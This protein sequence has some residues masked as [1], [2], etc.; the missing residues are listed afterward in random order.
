[1]PFSQ[2]WSYA[3][4]VKQ[5]NLHIQYY[6]YILFSKI[7]TKDGLEYKFRILPLNSDWRNWKSL[8]VLK[9]KK[10]KRGNS[11]VSFQAINF[12]SICK[13][14]SS[15]QPQGTLGFNQDSRLQ[16]VSTWFADE[17]KCS[18]YVAIL[19]SYTHT[20]TLTH[21]HAQYIIVL[22]I[23]TAQLL[24]HFFELSHDLYFLWSFSN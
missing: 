7:P 14:T 13:K 18:N 2:C 9:K 19:I 24:E 8:L 4:Q 20:H 16:F 1:M 21:V 23:Y 10:K 11:F 3:K 17:C 5:H 12:Q 15:S 22:M 6:A